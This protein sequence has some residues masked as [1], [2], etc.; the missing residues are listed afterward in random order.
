MSL[1]SAT[2]GHTPE[3]SFSLQGH[4]L[5]IHVRTGFVTHKLMLGVVIKTVLT[6]RPVW[7]SG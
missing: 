6:A 1:I 5:F 3:S 4:G 2:G 7:L